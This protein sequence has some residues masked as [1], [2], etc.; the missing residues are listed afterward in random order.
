MLVWKDI[1]FK[2]NETGLDHERVSDLSHRYARRIGEL[3][4]TSNSYN[5]DSIASNI[6]EVHKN[7][8]E[9]TRTVLRWDDVPKDKQR[10]D[11]EQF[12]RAMFLGYKKSFGSTTEEIDQ[13]ISRLSGKTSE[14]DKGLSFY[15]SIESIVGFCENAGFSREEAV[16]FLQGLL[17]RKALYDPLY[18]REILNHPG[19]LGFE[20]KLAEPE[21]LARAIAENY[22]KSV[23]FDKNEVPKINDEEDIAKEFFARRKREG[24]FPDKFVV[25]SVDTQASAKSWRT[26]EQFAAITVAKLASVVT[27]GLVPGGVLGGINPV[28]LYGT[29]NRADLMIMNW[30]PRFQGG[31]IVP[32]ESFA[33][34]GF[35]CDFA[36]SMSVMIDGDKGR[37][38]DIIA[39]PNEEGILPYLFPSE[40]VMVLPTELQRATV[41][42]ITDLHHRL[43]RPSGEIATTLERCISYDPNVWRNFHYFNEWLQTTPEGNVLLEERIGRPVSELRTSDEIKSNIRDGV[44]RVQ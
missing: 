18:I 6:I 2:K 34:D 21:K 13:E 4:N 17:V 24:A 36:G 5:A 28:E 43:V 19:R 14:H 42:K 22:E 33:Q 12:M 10:L 26:Y 20:E 38:I 3:S 44:F 25:H 15:H 41:D 39:R 1:G 9:K 31:V 29:L 37:G 7:F 8:L 30:Y 27:Y 11:H 40:F 16:V 23:S 35:G 32:V